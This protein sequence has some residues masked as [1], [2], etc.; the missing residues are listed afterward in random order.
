MDNTILENIPNK[1]WIYLFKDYKDSI[2]YIWKAKNLKNR[3]SQYFNPNSVRKQDM[4]NKAHTVDFLQVKTESEAL[5]LED[6]LI[7]EHQPP[8]NNMLKWSNSYAYIKI[9]KEAF[10]QIIITRNKINDWSKYIWPK[11]N[12]RELK[13]F[14]QYLRYIIKRRWCKKTQF[15]QWKLCGDYHFGLCKWRCVFKN[16]TQYMSSWVCEGSIIQKLEM[17]SSLH[18]EWQPTKQEAINE[19]KSIIKII[20]QFFKWNTKPVEKEIKKQIQSA[21]DVENFERAAKL[22][23]IYLQIENLTE[24]QTV[25]LPKGISG[26][27]CQIREMSGWFVYI[28]LNFYEWKLIDVIINK[29]NKDDLDENSITSSLESELWNLIK[30]KHNKDNFIVS[31]KI[32][33][34]KTQSKEVVELIN[35]FLES[36]LVSESFKDENLLNDMLS[37]IQTK[38]KLKNFPYH[39]ECIDISHLSGDRASGWLSCFLWWIA[40]Y[41]LY[42][43]YK[44]TTKSSDDYEALKEVITKRFKDKIDI[45][46]WHNLPDLFILDGWK[47]QLWIL[48]ELLKEERF[49]Q[50]FQKIDFVSLWKWVARKTWWKL[51]WE[52]EKIFYFDSAMNIK[53]IDLDYNEP[54]HILVKLRNEAHR[55]SNSYRKSQM[56]KDFK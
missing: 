35:W 55:F 12:T 17:D 29:Q 11:H 15:N 31:P 18:S 50:V 51:K 33:I 19:Y 7:K 47:W 1:P 54:D 30:I 16:E 34:N 10:P 4:L 39:M 32:K 37:E 13:N 23:D 46:Q 53:S 27:I 48:K 20:E 49:N 2:L 6:N 36:Y 44:I 56:K 5:Y 42:R 22:R 9:T 21:I 52:K 8:F 45:N 41:N 25:V 43:K 26:Y 24:K 28:V 3:V 38:Y 14:L 40:N